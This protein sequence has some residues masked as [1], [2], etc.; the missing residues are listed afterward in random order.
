MK[1]RG[2]GEF[3][4]VSREDHQPAEEPAQDDEKIREYISSI[5]NCE[6]LRVPLDILKYIFI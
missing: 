5:S 4:E 2:D 6:L 3:E 1:M